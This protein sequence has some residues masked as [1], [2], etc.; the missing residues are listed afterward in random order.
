MHIW[1]ANTVLCSFCKFLGET[2]V[3]I[4]FDSLTAFMLNVFGKDYGWDF[5]MVFLCHHIHQRLSFLDFIMKQL[6]IIIFQVIIYW[7][8]NVF[9]Y[10]G[11][12]HTKYRYSNSQLHRSKA[13]GEANKPCYQQWNRSIEKMVCFRKQFTINLIIHCERHIG[14]F[15]KRL[16][17]WV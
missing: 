5:R 7:F 8:L 16:F 13:K 11:K 12:M 4:F 1:T 14:W 17:V 15:G 9:M 6:T 3:H 2:P 10:Q